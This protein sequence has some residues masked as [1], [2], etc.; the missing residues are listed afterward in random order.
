MHFALVIEVGP[1]VGLSSAS[2]LRAV[3]A[4]VLDWDGVVPGNLVLRNAQS[5]G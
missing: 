3:A 2:C 1:L 5:R 4:Q